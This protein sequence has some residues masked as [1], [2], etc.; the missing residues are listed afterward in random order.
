MCEL[1]TAFATGN[2]QSQDGIVAAV[3]AENLGDHVKGEKNEKIMFR[4][5]S[6]AHFQHQSMKSSITVFVAAP[7]GRNARKIRRLER[8]AALLIRNAVVGSRRT[9]RSV[10]VNARPDSYRI[11]SNAYHGATTVSHFPILY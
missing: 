2:Q 1:R 9:I 11:T 6:I 5:V 7:S 3:A 10:T 4:L 8:F